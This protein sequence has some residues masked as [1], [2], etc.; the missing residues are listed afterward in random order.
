MSALARLNPISRRRLL[1]PAVVIASLAA[2]AA[3]SAGLA[4]AL[5]GTQPTARQTASLQIDRL[6]S[7]GYIAS[8]C[9]REGTLMVNPKTRRRV[10]VRYA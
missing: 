9:T 7:Q 3:G 1:A 5:D 10:T 4:T 6:E 2:A 8:S